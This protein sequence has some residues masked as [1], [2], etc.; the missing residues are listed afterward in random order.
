MVLALFLLYI[1][2]YILLSNVPSYW[3]LTF[4]V[5][6]LPC[7]VNRICFWDDRVTK[8]GFHLLS[9]MVG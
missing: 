7:K 6:C 5:T 9:V 4:M 8:M 2:H 3:F 1:T